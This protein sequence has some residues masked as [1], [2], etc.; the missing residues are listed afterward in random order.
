MRLLLSFMALQIYVILFQPFVL[1]RA[2]I[3]STSFTSMETYAQNKWGLQMPTAEGP[4]DCVP[5][6]ALVHCP[7]FVHLLINISSQI[8]FIEYILWVF[9][10]ALALSASDL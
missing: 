1:T 8:V 7:P 2:V 4:V 10:P 5:Q 3:V 9:A 6:A